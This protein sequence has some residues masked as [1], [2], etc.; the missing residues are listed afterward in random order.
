MKDD[1]QWGPNQCLIKFDTEPTV[2]VKS[3]EEVY[4]F[5]ERT[6]LQ[7][8]IFAAKPDGNDEDDGYVLIVA[9]HAGEDLCRLHIFDAKKIGDGPVASVELE[10]HLPPGLHGYWSN[11]VHK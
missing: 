8:P 4:Y 9:N 7:E 1:V 3:D 2:G 11:A 10:D 6:F 5:G